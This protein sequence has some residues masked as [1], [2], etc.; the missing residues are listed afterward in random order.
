MF[1][2]V[3]IDSVT[4]ILKLNASDVKY[5]LEALMKDNEKVLAFMHETSN[6]FLQSLDIQMSF[7]NLYLDYC[8]RIYAVL[9]EGEAPI[10]ST[11]T[12]SSVLESAQQEKHGGRERHTKY[13]TEIINRN[14]AMSLLFADFSQE[15]IKRLSLSDEA[16]TMLSLHRGDENTAKM[17]GM[18]PIMEGTTGYKVVSSDIMENQSPSAVKEVKQFFI[19]CQM[20]EYLVLFFRFFESQ[21]EANELEKMFSA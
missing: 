1:P 21:D 3:T 12:I 4:K 5:S 7:V 13:F 11:D 8:I 18:T 6:F 20:Q 10:V 16:L 2:Q 9:L 15:L 17:E 19:A 14:K